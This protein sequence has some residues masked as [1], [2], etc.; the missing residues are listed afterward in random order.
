[1]TF[2]PSKDAA[3]TSGGQAEE[4]GNVW[5]FAE[6]A[7]IAIREMEWARDHPLPP[8]LRRR[9]D[10]A[11]E[12]RDSIIYFGNLA[13]WTDDEENIVNRACKATMHTGAL[14]CLT[15]LGRSFP[16]GGR[17]LESG[18]VRDLLLSACAK[19]VQGGGPDLRWV[20]LP[21]EEAR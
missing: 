9:A 18:G 3:K 1:M 16:Y 21:A 2:I 7:E 10:A 4:E 11:W 20:F 17:T 8:D 19:L 15:N 14:P 13:D 6:L 12:V 5:T